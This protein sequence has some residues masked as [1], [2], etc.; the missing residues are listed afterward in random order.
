M[1]YSNSW[2][3]THPPGSELAKNIDEAIR[4]LRL[5]IHERMDHVVADWEADPVVPVGS[6][7]IAK[8]KYADYNDGNSIGNKVVVAADIRAFLS[9]KVTATTTASGQLNLD[10]DEINTETGENW[11]IVDFAGYNWIGLSGAAD[12]ATYATQDNAQNTIRF[13]IKDFN[14]TAKTNATITG[15][16][17][18]FFTTNI[19]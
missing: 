16:L 7:A 2:D 14:G 18:L 4:R 1:V 10:L 6:G 17:I 8:A 3:D 5:D 9:I 19:P 11:Q 13:I 15:Y 12:D